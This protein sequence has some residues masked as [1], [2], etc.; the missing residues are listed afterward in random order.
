[1]GTKIDQRIGTYLCTYIGIGPSVGR[2][3]RCHSERNARRG[4]LLPAID[5]ENERCLLLVFHNAAILWIDAKP[6]KYTKDNDDGCPVLVV[7][8][9]TGFEK[10]SEGNRKSI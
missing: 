9:V 10:K 6:G 3:V 8:L 1:M 2:H 5:T 4:L 7:A